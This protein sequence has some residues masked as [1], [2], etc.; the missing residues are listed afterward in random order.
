MLAPRLHAFG[1]WL[2]FAAVVGVARPSGAEPRTLAFATAAPD[3]TAWARELR[4]FSRDVEQ[5]TNGSVHVKWYFGGIAGSELDVLG[6]IRRGQLD[7]AI[8][9]ATCTRLAPSLLVTRIPGLF[10]TRAELRATLGLL[11]PTI[12]AELHKAGFVSLVEAVIGPSIVLSRVPVRS[13]EELKKLRIWRWDLDDGLEIARAVGLDIVPTPVE[14]AAEAYDEHRFDAFAA[15]PTAALAFQ[16]STQARYFSNLVIDYLPGCFFMSR[17]SFEALDPEVRVAV[18]SAIAK[19]EAHL[20][21]VSAEQD[22]LLVSRLFEQQGLKPVPV[23]REFRV[24]FLEAADRAR[25]R[26]ATQ[27]VPA[28]LLER[29]IAFLTE[30]RRAHPR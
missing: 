30:Y 20:E 24:A 21:F 12:H 25:A 14:K 15:L 11:R 19:T 1:R 3:G 29:V 17:D 23:S 4:A 9:S 18:R 2:A 6:R 5:Q 26:R 8:S 7:G 16:W 28:A 27:L 10:R 13:F 22:D